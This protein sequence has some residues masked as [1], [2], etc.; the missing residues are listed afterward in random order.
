[1]MSNTDP[2][3]NREQTEVLVKGKQFLP[4]RRH[5]PCPFLI[6]PSVFSSVYF[7]LT[8]KLWCTVVPHL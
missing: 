7:L 5:T 8:R 3:K 4:L 1:M 2:T 6:A